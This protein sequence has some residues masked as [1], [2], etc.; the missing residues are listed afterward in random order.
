MER[1]GVDKTMTVRTPSQTYAPPPLWV[2]G[3]KEDRR[4]LVLP[5]IPGPTLVEEKGGNSSTVLGKT[6][7]DKKRQDG[8]EG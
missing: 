1:S 7:I 4:I 8:K 6:R 5:F 2:F 3:D